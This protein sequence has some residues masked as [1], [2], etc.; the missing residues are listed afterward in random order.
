MYYLP[1]IPSKGKLLQCSFGRGL[2][3]TIDS[4]GHWDSQSTQ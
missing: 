4:A 2:P 3:H 1:E